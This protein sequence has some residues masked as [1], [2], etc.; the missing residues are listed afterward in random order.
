MDGEPGETVEMAAAAPLTYIH[1]DDDQG[2]NVMTLRPARSNARWLKG[3]TP[4]PKWATDPDWILHY[5]RALP[6]I[7]YLCRSVDW[8]T[9]IVTGYAHPQAATHYRCRVTT[10]AQQ[11]RLL[12]ESGMLTVI[13]QGRSAMD[14]QLA[15]STDYAVQ[16][17]AGAR[18]EEERDED[19]SDETGRAAS[20]ASGYQKID[21]LDD[22]SGYQF[23]ASQNIDS[24]AASGYQEIDRQPIKKLIAPIDTLSDT[25]QRH[26]PATQGASAHAADAPAVAKRKPA[27]PAPGAPEREY[28]VAFMELLS[29]LR[30]GAPLS[31]RDATWSAT[32]RFWNW[33]GAGQPAD[34]EDVAACYRLTLLDPMYDGRSLEL[35]GQG[36]LTDRY[37]VYLRSGRKGYEQAMLRKRK[38]ATGEYDRA[39]AARVAAGASRGPTR[40]TA[41]MGRERYAA[42]RQQLA[43]QGGR[44]E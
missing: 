42:R 14:L 26:L 15:A 23:F 12:R 24:L 13:R 34:P 5:G 18:A 10:I 27:K 30:D 33:H 11:F 3:S 2:S 43:A 32:K 25:S 7:A 20:P 36:G 19:T 40:V 16:L 4:L 31:N 1:E 6:L 35:Y 29:T 22:G 39:A 8:D 21:N 9:G 37:A 17:P 38:A 44:D 41:Q 28:R